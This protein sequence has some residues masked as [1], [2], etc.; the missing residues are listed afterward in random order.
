M[1]AAPEA[2]HIVSE[3]PL[4][5]AV[6]ESGSLESKI[7]LSSLN[8]VYIYD[9]ETGTNSYVNPQYTRLTGYSLENLETLG[10]GGFFALFHPEDQERLGDQLERISQAHDDETFEFEYRLRHADGHWIWCLSRDT[11]FERDRQ[12]RARRII[13]TFVDFTARL[14]AEKNWNVSASF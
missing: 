8:G 6:A 13:G 9:L 10:T 12:G 4:Q 3:N 1:D 11:V 7:L 5:A 14:K 2:T